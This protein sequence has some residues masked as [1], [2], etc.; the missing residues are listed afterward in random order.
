MTDTA[1]QKRN[2][3]EEIKQIINDQTGAEVKSETDTLDSL[4]FDELDHIEVVMAVEEHFD[5]EDISDDD[6]EKIKT[7]QDLVKAVEGRIK[8]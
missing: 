1:T 7:V 2:V 5:I 8:R 6:V 4:G 3:L